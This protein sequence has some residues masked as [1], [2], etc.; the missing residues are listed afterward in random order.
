MT[1]RGQVARVMSDFMQSNDV[2]F[3]PAHALD[4]DIQNLQRMASRHTYEG[5]AAQR[6]LEGI[7]AQTNFYDARESSGAKLAVLKA[8]SA[9]IH[10]ENRP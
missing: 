5:D 6:V 1:S 2:P 9:M 7:Y 10:P 4:L 3:A 8:V